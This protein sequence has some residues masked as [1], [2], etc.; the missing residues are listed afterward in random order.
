MLSL[1]PVLACAQLPAENGFRVYFPCISCHGDN[2]EGSPAI[3]APSLH[4]QSAAYISR[5]LR[6]FRDG[7]R[8]H[9][10][11]DT[12]GAQ[13]A[14]MAANLDD[15][16]IEV[17]ASHVASLPSPGADSQQTDGQAPADFAYCTA[18]HG[19]HGRGNEAFDA[20]RIGGMDRTYLERQLRNFRDGHRGSGDAGSPA[21][22][23]RNALPR[24]L[25]DDSIENLA[26]YIETL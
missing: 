25:S 15:E 3:N 9:Y 13:M 7:R 10:P 26:R 8:G 23:M 22:V 11:A 21:A 14:L 20:P 1:V 12:W 4:G 5:Q 16:A 2:G 24:D 18:C 19:K 6:D 17:L